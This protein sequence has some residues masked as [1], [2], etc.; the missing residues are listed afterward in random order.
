MAR[1]REHERSYEWSFFTELAF[2]T[3]FSV[4][5]ILNSI[6]GSLELIPGDTGHKLGAI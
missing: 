4:L 3:P 1:D 2:T 5:F 6:S